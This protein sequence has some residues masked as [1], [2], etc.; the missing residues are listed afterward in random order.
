MMIILIMLDVSKFKYH[1]SFFFDVSH[2]S[3]LE[4][5]PEAT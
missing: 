1:A 3:A 5:S 4:E 2:E